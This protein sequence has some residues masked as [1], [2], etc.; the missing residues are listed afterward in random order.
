MTENAHYRMF[1][2]C[3]P[4]SSMSQVEEHY[5]CTA[6]QIEHLKKNREGRQCD[7][8]QVQLT[9]LVLPDHMCVLDLV[10][11]QI[12]NTNMSKNI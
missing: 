1:V 11:F 9:T 4:S 6:I 7:A 5:T 12:P 10:L 3:S 8:S 2:S